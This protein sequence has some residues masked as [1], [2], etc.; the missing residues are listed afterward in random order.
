MSEKLLLLGNYGSPYSRK[1]ISLLRY[2]RIPYELLWGDAA[3][4]PLH[5]GKQ[6]P[7]AKP[8]LLPTVYIP[9]D[10]GKLQALTDS[11]PLIRRFEQDY[12]GRSVIP[13]SPALMFLNSLLEDFADE[14]G[15]KYMFHYRWSRE[16]DIEWAGTIIPLWISSVMPSTVHQ[17]I[18]TMFAER[19]V[20]RLHYVGSNPQTQPI[21]EASYKR[22]LVALNVHFEQHQFLFGDRP[23]S[24]DFAFFGQLSQLVA[25]DPTPMQIAREIAPRVVAWTNICDDL[26]GLAVEESDWLDIQSIPS[27]LIDVFKEVASGYVPAMLENA[28]AVQ[29]GKAEWHTPIDGA[30]W[31]QKTFPYQAKCLSALRDEYSRLATGDQQTLDRILERAGCDALV[32]R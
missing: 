10:D 29:S 3:N 13:D 7:K 20:S 24:A 9:D 18:K 12:S 8:A 19:Q 11:T 30:I 32:A 16:A 28:D 5:L 23:S 27:S 4:P 17:K 31:K 25:V 15:T 14:W 22:L 2:R 26:S 21:I 1:M 6:L